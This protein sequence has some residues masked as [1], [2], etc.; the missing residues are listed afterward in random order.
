MAA[1]L[2][3]SLTQQILDVD[4]GNALRSLRS[5]LIQISNINDV[6]WAPYGGTGYKAL[7]LGGRTVTA[8]DQDAA[9]L[10]SAITEALSLLAVYRGTATIASGGAITTGASGHDFDTPIRKVTGDGLIA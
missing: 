7:P 8:S 6:F 4:V 1:G 3:A 10:G 2:N 9:D 5:A